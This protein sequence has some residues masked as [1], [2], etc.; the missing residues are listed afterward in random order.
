M[1][2]VVYMELVIWRA[3]DQSEEKGTSK[4]LLIIRQSQKI[5]LWE[6]L[7]EKFAPYFHKKDSDPYIIWYYIS[8]NVCSKKITPV[9][10][11][12]P[13][14]NCNKD[15]KFPLVNYENLELGYKLKEEKKNLVKAESEPKDRVAKELSTEKDI[16]THYDKGRKDKLIV[17][18]SI[19]DQV[20]TL[21]ADHGDAKSLGSGESNPKP[22]A[23]GPTIQAT[24]I[25]QG[26]D[27]TVEDVQF[28]PS[29]LFTI[30][31]LIGVVDLGL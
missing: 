22:S 30:G 10:G 29:R 13:C 14:L 3:L 5:T 15:C 20:S 12:Y 1:W 9:N 2:L 16:T 31:R 11:V 27:D 24:D 25:F 6:D 19:H 26:H 21:A 18:W 4:L 28:C 8:C 7:G 23:E 17:L